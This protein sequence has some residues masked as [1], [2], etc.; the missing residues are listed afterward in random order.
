[1]SSDGA[2]AWDDEVL[3][4][5][6]Q[7]SGDTGAMRSVQSDGITDISSD[8]RQVVELLQ[9]NSSGSSGTAEPPDGWYGRTEQYMGF[10]AFSLAI[11]M[12]L[13]VFLIFSQNLRR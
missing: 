12:G 5:L 8:I 9:E 10:S 3:T 7:V 4:I 1:M 2:S 11:C 13:L 6:R